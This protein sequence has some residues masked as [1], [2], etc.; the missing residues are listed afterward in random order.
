MTAEVNGYE[1]AKCETCVSFDQDV[2]DQPCSDHY[3]HI[4]SSWHPACEAYVERDE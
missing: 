1:R 2:C 4:L 3:G